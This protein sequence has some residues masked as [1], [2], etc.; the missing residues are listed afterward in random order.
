MNK[1]G[2]FYLACYLLDREKDS[3]E[4]GSFVGA[5][6]LAPFPIEEVPMSGVM[7]HE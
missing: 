3:K 7:R 1:A 2:E 5:R 4:V 6:D